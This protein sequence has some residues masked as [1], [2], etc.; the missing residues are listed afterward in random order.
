MEVG[1]AA[2]AGRQIYEFIM[3]LEEVCEDELGKVKR[4]LEI[5]RQSV[6]RAFG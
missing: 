6:C 2:D 5:L 3:P 1:R 4:E